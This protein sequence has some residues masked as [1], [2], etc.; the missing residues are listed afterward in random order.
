[1][2]S[3]GHHEATQGE[4]VEAMPLD[5]DESKEELDA[6]LDAAVVQPQP[7]KQPNVTRQGNE[8]HI[9]QLLPTMPSTKALQQYIEDAYQYYLSIKPKLSQWWEDFKSLDEKHGGQ[10]YPSILK[11]AQSR[12]KDEKQVQWIT[13]MIGPTPQLYQSTTKNRRKQEW[14]K[15]PWLGDWIARRQDGFW[16]PSH[17]AKIK[18]LANTLKKKLQGLD[19]VRSGA[20]YLV[21]MMATYMKLKEQVDAVFGGQALDLSKGPTEAN[22]A[23]F[24]DYMA[25]QKAVTRV[26]LRLWQEWK[27][28]NGVGKGDPIHVTINQLLNATG[29]IQDAPGRK[30]LEAAKL[31][32]MLMTHADNFNMPLPEDQRKPPE[33]APEPKPARSN[34]KIM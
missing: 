13:Q 9:S 26:Q 6:I 11:F 31:A 19:A 17:P 25:M 29:Q 3:N 14:Q 23:R 10:K 32:R 5:L 21:Q 27:E 28:A 1:M 2:P 22:K 34:G 33:K 4:I 12:T 24:Y 8:S 20:P 16:A 15:V 30:E 18:C 7:L